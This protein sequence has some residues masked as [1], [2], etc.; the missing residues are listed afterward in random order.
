MNKQNDEAMVKMDVESSKRLEAE[1]VQHML[2]HEVEV[3]DYHARENWMHTGVLRKVYGE[4]D[5]HGLQIFYVYDDS[6]ARR[7]GIVAFSAHDVDQI[8]AHH[9]SITLRKV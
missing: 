2:G 8:G 7:E 5:E 9:S 1:I 3:H 6:Y 4:V